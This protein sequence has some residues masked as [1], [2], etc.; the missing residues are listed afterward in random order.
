MAMEMAVWHAG[1]QLQKSSF[2]VVPLLGASSQQGGVIPFLLRI[3]GQKYPLT[4][5]PVIRVN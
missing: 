1:I 3:C 4:Q 2:R 5:I